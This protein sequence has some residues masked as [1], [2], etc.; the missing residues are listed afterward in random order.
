ML[1]ISQPWDRAGFV[2][3]S[4]RNAI[5]STQQSGGCHKAGRPVNGGDSTLSEG[6]VHSAASRPSL[7]AAAAAGVWLVLS[8]LGKRGLSLARTCCLSSTCWVSHCWSC[9]STCCKPAT[10]SAFTCCSAS[11]IWCTTCAIL[12]GKG[13]SQPV[14]ENRLYRQGA[15]LWWLATTQSPIAGPQQPGTNPCELTW[16]LLVLLK[17]LRSGGLR[18]L[19]HSESE[20][21]QSES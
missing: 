4:C 10:F 11:R 20:L 17:L 8:L 12:S 9:S 13:G 16:L 15:R 18:A 6:P 5:C 1:A 3:Q 7:D 14:T 21:G 19:H 2:S